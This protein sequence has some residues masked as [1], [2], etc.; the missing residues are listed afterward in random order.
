M[1]S[2]RG[3]FEQIFALRVELRREHTEVVV[4][5]SALK[6]ALLFTTTLAKL[7]VFYLQ[8]NTEAFEEEYAI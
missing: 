4:N 3:P 2:S 5:R 7:E 8:N 6:D 1:P